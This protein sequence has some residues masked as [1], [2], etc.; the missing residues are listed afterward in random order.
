MK[1]KHILIMFCVVALIQL[2]VPAQMIYNQEKVLN[3]GKA[4]KFKTRP[5]DPNDP[6]RGKYIT[7]RY[8][9]NSF[10]TRDTTWR[11][12]DAVYVYLKDSLGYAQI[13]TI[14]K[15]K[16]NLKTDYVVAKATH[17]RS[18]KNYSN[19]SARIHFDLPFNRFYMEEYKAKPAEDAIRVRRNDT[20]L[21]DVYS[22]VYVKDGEAVLENVF[23]N[24]VPII[25]YIKEKDNQ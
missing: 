14:S 23:I 17:F 7:L 25:D 13:D 19:K 11:R 24:D 9:I 4:Y 21:K 8:E 22:L 10:K 15:Y 2:F 5:I 12:G 3:D 18:F 6:F 16:L 20:D 1:K